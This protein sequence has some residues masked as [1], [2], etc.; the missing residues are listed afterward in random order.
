MSNGASRL[1]GQT[2]W[3]CFLFQYERVNKPG[4]TNAQSGYN[5]L[6]YSWFSKSWSPFSQGRLNLE[7][8][9]VD[10]IVSLPLHFVWRNLLIVGFKSVYGMEIL[11]G[12]RSKANLAA[13]SALS[14]PLTPIWF[15]IQCIIISL[16]LDI[17]SS[18]LSSLTINGFSS[19]LFLSDV[20]TESKS[21]NMINLLCLFL[22]MMLRARSMAYTYAVKLELFIGRAFLWMIL[23][24][25]AAHAVL[26]SSLEPTVNTYWW[27]GWCKRIVWNF[28][29]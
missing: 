14:F 16:W 9:I 12:L 28:S 10:V 7:A 27:S 4:M 20:N 8:F 21:E 17:E 19:F 22:E 13:E 11:S 15:G 29:R 1:T 18:L 26:L 6:F 23:L 2:Q 25:I 5:D 3:L 24:R